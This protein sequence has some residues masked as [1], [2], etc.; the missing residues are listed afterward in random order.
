MR[1]NPL[2]PTFTAM[3]KI[4]QTEMNL[5]L[6]CGTIPVADLGQSS[7]RALVASVTW[8]GPAVSLTRE[9]QDYAARFGLS[10][11][12]LAQVFETAFLKVT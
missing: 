5:C 1:P 9:T 8:S 2:I 11:Q 10:S 4:L 7:A 6:D 3:P 12:H